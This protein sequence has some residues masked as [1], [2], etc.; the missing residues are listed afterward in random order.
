MLTLFLSTTHIDI[1]EN[2]AVILSPSG[3]VLE[4]QEGVCTLILAPAF[5]MNIFTLLRHFKLSYKRLAKIK[6]SHAGVNRTQSLCISQWASKQ[7]RVA[8]WNGSCNTAHWILHSHYWMYFYGLIHNHHKTPKHQKSQ[9]R[10][11][12]GKQY[13]QRSRIPNRGT[14]H[15]GFVAATF[16]TAKNRNQP[17]C[18]PLIFQ[19]LSN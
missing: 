17:C 8:M 7:L 2:G 12:L 15:L 14:G 3:L 10:L 6:T 19:E 1:T 4:K 5:L 13:T 9:S 16:T 11:E 18:P